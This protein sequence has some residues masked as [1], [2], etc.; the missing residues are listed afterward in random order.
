M[1]HRVRWG[2]GLLLFWIILSSIVTLTRSELESL[3]FN[4]EFETEHGDDESLLRAGGEEDSW[5]ELYSEHLEDEHL[6]DEEPPPLPPPDLTL[7]PEP[8][9][10]SNGEGGTADDA[11]SS[12]ELVVKEE[13]QLF[14]RELINFYRE[15]SLR[16]KRCIKLPF[17]SSSSLVLI[18]DFVLFFPAYARFTYDIKLDPSNNYLETKVSSAFAYPFLCHGKGYVIQTDG[19]YRLDDFR[20]TEQQGV[21]YEE[22]RAYPKLTKVNDEWSMGAG[23]RVLHVS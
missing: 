14:N 5:P 8:G 11:M 9:H 18:S 7:H 2:W 16:E 19:I 4:F 20:P 12:L 15:Q 6:E 22:S 10:L 21:I 13:I 23:D 17:K 3:D 1:G